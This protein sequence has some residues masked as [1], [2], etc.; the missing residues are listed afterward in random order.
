MEGKNG[1]TLKPFEK[2][3]SGN[4]NGRPKGS[5]NR[6]TI[7]RHWL[8]VN[9]NLKNP[10]TGQEETMSQEDLMTLALIKK[11]R[12]GDVNAYKALMDSGYGAPV[13]Q[14]EQTNTDIDLSGLTTDELKELLK[15][16]D[17]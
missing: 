6:S 2:G 12:E 14:I 16:D 10:L 11:A 5:K 15:G 8:Q 4:P 1:G 7:A 13:Q 9:Q 17:E 3:E